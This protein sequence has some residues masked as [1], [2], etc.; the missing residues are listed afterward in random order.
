MGPT[1]AL[2]DAVALPL[3]V[4][5][6]PVAQAT[7]LNVLIVG[8]DDNT[9]DAAIATLVESSCQ[10]TC[11]WTPY[12]PLPARGTHATVVIRDVVTLSSEQQ[13]A[14]LAWLNQE[15]GFHPQLI[16][17]SSVPVYPLVADGV[18]LPELYYRLNT[19][20]LNI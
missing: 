1:D 10:P 11:W 5:E 2:P 8:A 19:V 9:I 20:L 7:P 16:A 3:S 14:W 18:Y 4:S 12:E 6:W 17:T 13:E 15:D